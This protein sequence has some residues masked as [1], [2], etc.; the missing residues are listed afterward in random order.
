[1]FNLKDLVD[2]PS[3]HDLTNYGV[4][5]E[6]RP[7]KAVVHFRTPLE[8]KKRNV[9][10]SCGWPGLLSVNGHTGEVVCMRSGC[11]HDH[12]FGE[13]DEVLSLELLV[14]IT[15]KRREEKKA[16]FRERLDALLKEGVN[17]KFLTPDA[18]SRILQAV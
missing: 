16:K 18:S 1:M 15:T 11:G 10:D 13:R 9:C 14:N 5:T 4:I 12:G 6:L 8:P 2:V 7:G 3:R 17:E